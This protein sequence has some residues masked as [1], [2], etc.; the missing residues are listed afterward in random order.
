MKRGHSMYFDCSSP[1]F[2]LSH[3]IRFIPAIIY[4]SW[5]LL[6]IPNPYLLILLV[7]SLFLKPF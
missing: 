3:L 6:N 2:K 1:R 4:P 5:T 7:P